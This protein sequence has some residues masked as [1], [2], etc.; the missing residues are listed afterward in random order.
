MNFPAGKFKPKWWVE[1]QG[2]KN[3]ERGA[4]QKKGTFIFEKFLC[5]K[6][7][8]LL[9]FSPLCAAIY[10]NLAEMGVSLLN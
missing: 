10:A 3:R 1:K 6:S 9:S 7:N 8:I 2:R 5:K 4:R